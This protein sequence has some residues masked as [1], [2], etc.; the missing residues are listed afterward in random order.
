MSEKLSDNEVHDRLIAASDALGEDEGVTV[1]GN[2]AL[3]AARAMLTKLQLGLLLI[4]DR[5]AGAL[6]EQQPKPSIA[7]SEPRDQQNGD[8]HDR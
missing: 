2:T 3:E 5:H 8:P 1:H 4:S 6:P 7:T